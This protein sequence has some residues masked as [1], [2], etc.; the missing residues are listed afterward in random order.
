MLRKGVSGERGQGGGGGYEGLTRGIR[1][2]RILDWE[3][4]RVNVMSRG[5]INVTRT[6]DGSVV[7]PITN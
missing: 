6:T 4:S 3:G 1:R 5:K 2:I 7:V